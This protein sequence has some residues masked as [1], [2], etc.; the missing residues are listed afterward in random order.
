MSGK[1]R[2]HPAGGVF[3]PPPAVPPRPLRADELAPVE[4]E[5][6]VSFV[7]HSPGF[8]GLLQEPGGLLPSFVIKIDFS[9]SKVCL[10]RIGAAGD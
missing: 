8:Q 7:V 10:R 9:D 5:Q 4:A 1:I 6:L 3:P 2:V